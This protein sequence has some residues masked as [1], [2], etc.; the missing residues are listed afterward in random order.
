MLHQTGSGVLG[1]VFRAFDS[2]RDRLVAIKAFRLDLLPEQIVRLA[3]ALRRLQ[4]TPPVHPLIVPL[5]DVGLEGTMPYVVMA[6]QPGE[7][8][9][10]VLRRAL[11]MSIDRALRILRPLAATLVSAGGAGVLHGALHPRD[12]FVHEDEDGLAGV[13]GFGIVQALE[14]AGMSSPLLRRPYVAPERG[15][16]P[17]DARADVFSLG[18]IAHELLTGRRP[19]A[20]GE[21]DGVFAKEMAPE[22]R[23]RLRKVLSTALNE[24]A[25]QRFNSADALIAALD[26]VGQR[27]SAAPLKAPVAPAIVESQKDLGGPLSPD[28]EEK[29]SEVFL[30]QQPV[31]PVVAAPL[32]AANVAKVAP[33]IAPIEDIAP[34]AMIVPA[35]A[36]AHEWLDT[37]L[38]SPSYEVPAGIFDTVAIPQPR[39]SAVLLKTF[40]YAA[41]GLVFGVGGGLLVART[42]FAAPVEPAAESTS[43]AARAPVQP[44]PTPL[45]ETDAPRPAPAPTSAPVTP[46]VAPAERER[47]DPPAA[48]DARPAVAA[49][50]L[51]VRSQPSGALVTIDGRHFGETPVVANGLAPG[52]YDV[53]VARPGHVPRTERVT[54]RATAPVRTLDVT[55]APG[56]ESTPTVASTSTRGAIDVDSRPRGARVIVD[57]RFVGLAPLRL[58]DV[59][60]G[61]H[62][63][64]LEL[65]GYRSATGRVRVDAGRTVALATTLRAVE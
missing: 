45:A 11:P 33:V 56:L 4:S 10:I 42:W 44:E 13:T 16:G 49:G 65:G 52:T 57:G 8:L 23:V 27:V 9:D 38:A 41:A 54:I 58:A 26:E 22:Q 46:P 35:V 63:V 48:R 36:Q 28:S 14:S 1:P 25:E 29:T 21:Q 37:A 32:A 64:T 2:P 53:R 17:W 6:F 50:R 5:L 30:A 59:G 31:E 19:A 60:P 47:P 3:D 39:R 40:L 55:L 61:D 15:S 43:I 7:T 34:T 20:S 62:Q 12:V 24:S 51:V 18:V